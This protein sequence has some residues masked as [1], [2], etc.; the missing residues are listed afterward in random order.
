M[1]G[2]IHKVINR[3]LSRQR[4]LSYAPLTNFLIWDNSKINRLIQIDSE[5]R[6]KGSSLVKPHLTCEVHKDYKEYQVYYY[7]SIFPSK[8]TISPCKVYF[9]WFVFIL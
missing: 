8:T 9:L 5:R 2:H 4:I 3:N 1:I 6:K 7:S